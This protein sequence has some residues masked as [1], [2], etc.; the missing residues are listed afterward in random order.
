MSREEFDRE[1]A[2]PNCLSDEEADSLL[3]GACWRRFLVMGDSL[4]AGVGDPSAGYRS[5]PWSQRLREAL[6]RQ[7]SGL[8]YVNTGH[9]GARAAEVRAGQLNRALDFRPDL[10]AVVCGG[11]DLLS[12]VFDADAVVAEIDTIVG[13]LRSSGADVIM[14]T[15]QDI[16]QAGRRWRTVRCASASASSM[17]AFGRSRPGTAR[18]WWSSGTWQSVPIRTSTART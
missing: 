2:D 18:F 1:A 6:E 4:A 7:Q 15:L 13:R 5:A 11:N 3:A 8:E 10:A 9:I 16:T 17:T 12:K 14:W